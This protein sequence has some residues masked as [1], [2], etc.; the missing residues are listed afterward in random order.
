MP[1]LIHWTQRVLEGSKIVL[2]FKIFKKMKLIKK[3]VFK[4]LVV[5]G[6]FAVSMLNLSVDFRRDNA[7]NIDL[8]TLS[9]TSQS[10]KAQNGRTLACAETIFVYCG[11]IF[12]YGSFYGIRMG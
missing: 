7:G 6:V 2:F 3:N 1:N 5:A 10:A 12:P 8:K 11:Y 9:L 4:G